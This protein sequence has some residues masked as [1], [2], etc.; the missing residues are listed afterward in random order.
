MLVV[1]LVHPQKG[2]EQLSLYTGLPGKVGRV[3][4][5]KLLKTPPA[6]LGT[7][8]FH[9]ETRVKHTGKDGQ[10]QMDP[11]GFEPRAFRMRSGCDTTTP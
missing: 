6:E 7:L 11:L 1:H 3:I 10:D 9:W 4:P 2:A 5:G 8:V